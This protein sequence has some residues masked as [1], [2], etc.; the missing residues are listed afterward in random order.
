MNIASAKQQIKDTVEAYLETDD[1]GMYIIAPVHQRP[2]F[3][4]GAPGIGKTAIMEQIAQELGI[5]IVSYSMTHHTR[6]SA[7]GLPRIEHH[8]FEGYE[9]ESSEYTMSEIIGA[10]YDYMERTDLRCGI[11]FLDEINCV[12]ETL[13]PSMLQFLQFKTFGKHKVPD[14]WIVVCAGNPAMYNKQVHEFDIVTLDRMREIDVEPDFSAFREYAMEVGLHPV[15]TTFL[16]TKKDCYYKIESRPGG[17]KSFVTTR[18]W[19][20]LARV[21]SLYERLGK[22]INRELIAQFLHDDDIV[23]QFSIYYSLFEKYRSDYQVSSILDGTVSGSIKKRAEEAQFDERIALLGLMVD[24]IATDC[25]SVLEQEAIVLGLRDVLRSIKE[26]MLH[27]GAVDILLTPLITK[28]EVELAQKQA[29][30]ILT[31]QALRKEKMTI[32]KLKEF[33]ALCTMEKTYE[34]DAAFHT[35]ERAYKEEVGKVNPAV[36][37]TNAKID[38]AFDFV[39][40][41]FSNREMLIFVAE[42][43]TRKAT[44]MFLAH[45]GNESY[46]AHNGQLKTDASLMGLEER[47]AQLAD[48]EGHVSQFAAHGDNSLLDFT[49]IDMSGA[50]T[51]GGGASSEAMTDTLKANA[52]SHNAP[53]Q[54]ESAEQETTPASNDG[55]GGNGVQATKAHHATSSDG[56]AGACDPQVLAAY[57]ADKDLEYAFTSD[58]AMHLPADKLPGTKVLDIGCRRG[59]GVYKIS[60]MVGNDGFAMGVDYIRPYIDEAKAGVDRAWHD[61]NLKKNNME[62]RFAYP[63]DLIGAGIGTGVFD[64]VYMNNALS[65]YYAPEVALAEAA[66]VLRSGGTLILDTVFADTERPYEVIEQARDLGN[67]IQASLT[68]EQSA[69]MFKEAGFADF[70][71]VYEADVEKDRGYKAGYKVPAAN[72]GE[73]TYK[74][75][76]LHMKKL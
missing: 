28:R 44:A 6:Q 70:D 35:L 26:D 20:D 27:G 75:V 52:L 51:I 36:D 15:V 14:G 16:E 46:Y 17:G 19:E 24:G 63:E 22:P 67:S 65:L 3:L 23:D 61:S 62:F 69:Q 59:R 56:T 60:S 53:V 73:T 72:D 48:L 8:N 76:T 32:Q 29:A 1:T 39:E 47:A 55:H 74:A 31:P 64:Y 54:T 40:E 68:R 9:Y 33:S 30:N 12:S 13:Y 43:A 49:S 66:R 71:L 2:I 5:G 21:I 25:T 37:A 11:L 42:L 18:G 38:N 34:G 41:C 57:Y 50:V 4:L 7:L 58:C 10:I 45:Y